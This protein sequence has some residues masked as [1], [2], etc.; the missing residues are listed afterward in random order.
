MSN[1]SHSRPFSAC[2]AFLR[3]NPHV[4]AV[5][6]P[7]QGIRAGA[8]KIRGTTRAKNMIWLVVSTL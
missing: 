2:Q 4:V 3:W 1:Q 7:P 5:F 6:E 8:P